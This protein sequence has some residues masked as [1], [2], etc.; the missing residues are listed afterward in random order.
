LVLV[1]SSLGVFVMKEAPQKAED[2]FDRTRRDEIWRSYVEFAKASKD[3]KGFFCILDDLTV[4]SLSQGL[5]HHKDAMI[6]FADPWTGEG[7]PGW[8]LRN[9]LALVRESC[10]D[11]TAWKVF[12]FR[13]SKQGDIGQSL[14]FNVAVEESAS[15]GGSK[16]F[17]SLCLCLYVVDSRDH[18]HYRFPYRR[19]PVLVRG[20]GEERQGP[21]WATRG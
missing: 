13:A 12:S 20:L 15:Q 3:S 18:L 21:V 1:T 10:P 7:H 4:V 6:G 8:P 2:V 9:L 11:R 16:S 17:A 19:W 5:V 14:V